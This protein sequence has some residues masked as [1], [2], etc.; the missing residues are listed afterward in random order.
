MPKEIRNQYLKEEYISRI[1]R[2]VDYIN[3][4]LDKKFELESLAR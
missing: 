4:N 1:N 2:I 3:R